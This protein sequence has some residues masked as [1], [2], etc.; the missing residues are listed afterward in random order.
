MCVRRLDA[1][2]GSQAVA[3][4][5]LRMLLA[6]DP[7]KAGQVEPISGLGT[8]DSGLILCLWD[9]SVELGPAVSLTSSPFSL[10]SLSLPPSIHLFAGEEKRGRE[11]SRGE[12]GRRDTLL[13]SSSVPGTKPHAVRMEHLRRSDEETACTGVV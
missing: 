9:C 12:R 13:G 4:P 8:W 1:R 5:S 11:G 10:A 3:C 6:H 2:L 7:G